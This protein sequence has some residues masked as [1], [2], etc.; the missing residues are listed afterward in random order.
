M[1]QSQSTSTSASTPTSQTPP[2]ATVPASQPTPNGSGMSQDTSVE[3]DIVFACDTTASMG[4]YIH[5]AQRSI[6]QIASDIRQKCKAS[7]RFALVEY[8]DHPPQD[9][10]FVTRIHK[11]TNSLA[12]MQSYVDK[13]Q[14]QG[15]GDGP[16]A[17]ADALDACAE[18]P[19]RQNAIKI[20]VWIADAP[21][22]G[23]GESG[24]GFSEGTKIDPLVALSKLKTKGVVTYAVGCEPCL[25]TSYKNARDFMMNVAESTE[26]KYLP[27]GKADLLSQVVVGGALEG[28]SM[29]GIWNQIET[30]LR[31]MKESGMTRQEVVNATAAKVSAAHTSNHVEVDSPYAEGYDYS[32]VHKMQDCSSLADM[33]KKGG[34]LSGLNPF[35][36]QKAVSYDY[37]EQ[38]AHVSAAPTSHKQLERWANLNCL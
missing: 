38:C 2:R 19:W 18:L 31:A 20:C 30:E 25:S 1:G 24:D 35:A 33:R 7:L 37:Q 5:Q 3:L 10:T 36:A 6:K 23:L 26:G 27:L 17:V 13:M 16:E 15:G 4:S 21:P 28:V 11:F 29:D 12:T 9:S 22:H 14:A 8:R 32:N 34:L